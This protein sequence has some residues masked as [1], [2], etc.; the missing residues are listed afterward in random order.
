MIDR[1]TTSPKFRSV[2]FFIPA[3]FGKEFRLN[4]K[5]SSG[6]PKAAKRSPIL[7]IGKENPWVDFLMVVMA[8]GIARRRVRTTTM[9]A[10]LPN[11]AAILQT[12]DIQR[13]F[14]MYLF[15]IGHPCC[16]QLTPVKTRYPLTSTRWPYRGL[17]ITANR[18]HMFL[19]SWLL[20]K[21]WFSDWIA[22]SCQVN[23]LK[24]R[25]DCSQAGLRIKS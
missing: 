20:T 9:T 22:G 13:W 23:L 3:L 16:D 21:C 10:E 11:I 8:S 24:T 17:K 19:W 12:R 7:I 4:L 18:A 14:T 5:R 1:Q 6:G 2:G 25:Q 15:D